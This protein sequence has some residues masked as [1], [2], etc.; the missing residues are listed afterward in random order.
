MKEKDQTTQTELPEAGTI[1]VNEMDKEV[2]EVTH[3]SASRLLALEAQLA[4]SL[5]LT[6]FLYKQIKD[7]CLYLLRAKTFREYVEEHTHMGYRTVSRYIAIADTYANAKEPEKLSTLGVRFLEEAGKNKKLVEQLNEGEYRDNDGNVWSLDE[8]AKMKNKERAALIDGL[9][10]EKDKL[11]KEN[12]LLKLEKGDIEKRW[13]ENQKLISTL[14]SEYGQGALQKITDELEIEQSL[15]LAQ[16][17]LM[18]TISRLQKIETNNARLLQLLAGVVSG[19][20]LAL[21][22]IQDTYIGEISAAGYQ[23]LPQFEK[24]IKEAE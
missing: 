22:T 7:E 3:E 14:E 18:A 9:E 16:G 17:E 23:D 1:I 5:L 15:T 21:S 8:L 11:K 4:S 2:L 13:Q 12:S 24:Q 20:I 19:S 6:A 10:K